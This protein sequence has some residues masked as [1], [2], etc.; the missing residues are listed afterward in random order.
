MFHLDTPDTE[1]SFHSEG[2]E[3]S[4]PNP[5]LVE[6]WIVDTALKEG[7]SVGALNIIFC[8]DAYLYEMNMEYLQ[9]DTLTD[10]ITFQYHEDPSVFIEGD[11]FISVERTNENAE[12]FAVSPEQELRRVIIHGTLHLLGYGDKTPEDQKLMTKKENEYLKLWEE[13]N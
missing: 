6:S 9:H 3:F 4:L 10:V 11:I 2:L 5:K 13:I 12:K 1:I 7:R 8:S